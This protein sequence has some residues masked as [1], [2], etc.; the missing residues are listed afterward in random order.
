MTP[1]QALIVALIGLAAGLLGGLAGIG[2]S[3][4]MLPGLAFLL[5][6]DVPAHHHVYMAAAMTVNIAVAIPSTIRHNRAN[7]V[8]LDA[9][10][11]LL[12]A[13]GIAILL[14]VLLSN[15]DDGKRLRVLLAGFIAA[16]CIMNLV[17]LILKHPEPAGHNERTN[18]LRLLTI[19]SLTGFVAGLLGIGGGVMMV[20]MLQFFCRIPLRQAIGTSSAVMCLT[21]VV[22]ATLKLLTLSQHDQSATYALVLAL[23]MSPLAILGAW[24]GARLTHSLP[25]PVVRG[26]ISVLLL[27]AA[28]KLAGFF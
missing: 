6:Y 12:P 3:L 7:V 28:A 25:L 22:G 2:G 14:G 4:V 20:P 17:K 27:A 5:G 8:R 16:Y 13:M 1:D 19:G 9:A 23:I 26:T 10:K 15:Q 21:A 24:T 18:L 11:V